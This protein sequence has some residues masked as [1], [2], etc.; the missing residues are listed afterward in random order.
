MYMEEMEA[1]KAAPKR[2]RCSSIIERF[3]DLLFSDTVMFKSKEADKG[4]KGRQSK[5]V[6]KGKRAN[7]V[8]ENKSQ[9]VRGKEKREQVERTLEYW[10]RLGKPL[11][12][13][14]QNYGHG[15]LLLLPDDLTET[16]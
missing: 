14:I 2:R 8:S 10:I 6:S 4:T 16:K 12:R 11:L 9:Q 7:Q 15:I 3:T 5:R 1:E 13:I